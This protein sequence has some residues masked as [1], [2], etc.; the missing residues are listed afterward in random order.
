MIYKIPCKI[1]PIPRNG[2]KSLK[3]D[4][5]PCVTTMISS[6][7]KNIPAIFNIFMIIPLSFI[8]III[9]AQC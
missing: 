4:A 2:I 6:A 9:L 3:M 1:A 7:N 8:I 5:M